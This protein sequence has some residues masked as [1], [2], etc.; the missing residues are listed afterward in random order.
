M[1]MMQTMRGYTKVLFYGLILVFVGTIIFDWG[2]NVTGLSTAES[3]IAQVNGEKISLAEFDLACNQV[4]ESYKQSGTEINDSQLNAIRNRVLDDL[5]QSKLV[6]QEIKKLNIHAT[7]KEITYYLWDRPPDFIQQMFRTEQGQFDV[8][9]YQAALKNPQLDAAWIGVE[10]ELRSRL[11]VQKLQDMLSAT[12]VVTESQVKEEY[13]K[14]NQKASVR[15]AQFPADKYRSAAV[16]I[17]PAELE[18]YYKEHQDELKEPE[19]RTIDYVIFST[20]PTQ[21]DSQAV[22]DTAAAVYQRALAGEDFAKLAEIYSED[23]SN[24][25][26]GGDLGF[27]PR[28]QMVKPFEEAAFAA[29]AGDIVGPVATNFGLH[30]IKVEERKTENNEE[31]VRARHILLRYQ[32]SA[33]TQDTAESDARF[34]AEQARQTSWAETV[35]SE[36]VQAQTS[37]PFVKGNGFVPGL[38][39]NFAASQYIFR[40]AVGS[41]SDIFEIPQGYVVV[42]VADIQKEHTKT[43]EDAKTQ[44]ETTLKEERW[45]QMAQQAAEKFYADLLKSGTE[46]F[47]TLAQRDTV[48]I[49]SP[50]LF[51]R[52]GFIT[53]V[54]RDQAFI[55]TA[56]SLKPSEFSKPV[57]GMRGSYIIQLLSID[58]FNEADYNI[59][60]D[61]VRSQLTDRAQ[62]EAFE[63]WLTALKEDADIKDERERF[64]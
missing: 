12:V 28:G 39:L 32:A 43:L 62:Q 56:F 24:N 22:Q 59:K 57:K 5:I 52:T 42:R 63:Q 34:F 53:G 60:K 8:A 58:P 46:S 17:T 9:R 27:F 45:K 35:A 3:T 48:T 26:R 33:Q 61:E 2:M 40:N 10:E 25:T 54:G 15:Y 7:D 31:K 64:F 44:I 49:N 37:T 18:K 19:K 51:T 38:G 6:R 23:E 41:I 21:R 4:L 55:G 30:I 47:E 11:P 13:L 1:G 50:E 20:Q 16:T 36:K 14:R 29:N